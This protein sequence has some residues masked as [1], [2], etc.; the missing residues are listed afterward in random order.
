M[1]RAD[2]IFSVKLGLITATLIFI[3]WVLNS[4]N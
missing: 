3:L 4:L 2:I 1:S